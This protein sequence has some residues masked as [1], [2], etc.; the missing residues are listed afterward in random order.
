MQILRTVCVTCCRLHFLLPKCP[1]RTKW[2]KDHFC[3][4][5]SQHFSSL[6]F[7]SLWLLVL[8]WHDIA[9]GVEPGHL[10]LVP[11]CDSHFCVQAVWLHPNHADK[12]QWS[13]FIASICD[14]QWWMPCYQQYACCLY[15]CVSTCIAHTY[16]VTSHTR[17][18]HYFIHPCHCH[19]RSIMVC[20]SDVSYFLVGDINDKS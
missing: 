11:K 19:V 6:A 17:V 16:Y 12:G 20:T 10:S 14:M 7:L 3:C 8:S 13:L 4:L 15:A 1:R 9:D 5:S 2:R 18:L